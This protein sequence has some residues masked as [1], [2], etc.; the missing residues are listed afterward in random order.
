MLW[1]QF[2]L[3]FL[4]NVHVQAAIVFGLGQGGA[5]EAYLYP[6]G[7]AFC[8]FGEGGAAGDGDVGGFTGGEGWHWG[9]GI[10]FLAIVVGIGQAD[11]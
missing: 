8:S 4:C 1:G 7:Q 2:A 5:G 3:F 10:K 11:G 6:E 9:F